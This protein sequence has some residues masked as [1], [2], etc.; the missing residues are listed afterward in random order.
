MGEVRMKKIGVIL[1]IVGLIIVMIPI[2]G[3]LYNKYEQQKLLDEFHAKL[4]SQFAENTVNESMVNEY[5]ELGSIFSNEST[6]ASDTG[7]SVDESAD[8]S[9]GGSIDESTSDTEETSAVTAEPDETAKP[10]V[11]GTLK[12][13]KLDIDVLV[14]N[15]I[16]DADLRVGVGHFPGTAAIGEIG[17][18]AIA[19]HRSYTFGKFFNRLNEMAIGD[20]IIVSDGINDYTYVVFKV[21]V[22]EPED[23]YVLNQVDDYRILTLVTCTPIHVATQRLIVQA[24]IDD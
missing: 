4:E 21:F 10:T 14:I 6:H 2:A 12:I 1:I 16:T 20:E 9:T 8:E 24:K 22:V 13:K 3:G 23:T 5:D 15:G 17:N 18:C 11:I 7:T 19:G